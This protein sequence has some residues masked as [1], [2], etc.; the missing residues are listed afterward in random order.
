MILGFSLAI[1]VRILHHYSSFSECWLVSPVQ[2]PVGSF[3]LSLPPW[4][5]PLVPPLI[6]AM[7]NKKSEKEGILTFLNVLVDYLISHKKI[8]NVLQ[9]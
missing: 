6:I 4:L 2:W 5:K 9:N 8:G 1:H 3:Y 7:Q